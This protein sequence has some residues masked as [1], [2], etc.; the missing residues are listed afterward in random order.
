MHKCQGWQNSETEFHSETLKDWGTGKGRILN[1]CH[2]SP[3]GK[4]AR[5]S[6]LREGSKEAK[7]LR[8]MSPNATFA[9]TVDEEL[10]LH[11]H[12]SPLV[13]WI[14][15]TCMIRFCHFA[16]RFPIII[17]GLRWHNLWFVSW[18]VFVLI[19]YVYCYLDLYFF[20]LQVRWSEFVRSQLKESL[21]PLTELDVNLQKG[22]L[23]FSPGIHI[24]IY[25]SVLLCILKW[26]LS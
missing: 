12:L 17:W 13:Q 23:D 11:N 21:T 3:A 22:C 7:L 5:G 25:T 16:L 18:F 24:Y 2:S 4:R 10:A 9:E 26:I 8:V 20:C 1:S 15:G 14:Q 6:P 19:F